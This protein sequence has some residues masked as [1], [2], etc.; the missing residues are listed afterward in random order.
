[1][2]IEESDIE[3]LAKTPRKTV[4]DEGTIVER[5][6]QELLDADRGNKAKGAN[7]VPWGLRVARTQP[8][9]ACGRANN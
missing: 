9:P 1:M 6:V 8:G 4:T 7:V 3:A 5:S 2:A